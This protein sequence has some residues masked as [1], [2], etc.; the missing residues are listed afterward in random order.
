MKLA[1]C[2][3]SPRGYPHSEAFREVAQALHAAAVALGHDAVLTDRADLPGRQTIVFGPNLLARFPQPLSP[4]AI[5]YNLEQ[6]GDGPWFEPA[7]LELFRKSP[8]WDYSER[9]AANLAAMGVPRPRV[10]PV[11]WDPVLERI[12]PSAEDIDVLFYGSTNPRRLRVLEALQQAGARVEIAWNV[13]GS[14]RDE[15][16][17]RSRVVLNL[18]YF[19]AKVFEIV[20][21]SYLLANG[22]AVVSERGAAPE[23]EAPFEEAVRFADYDGLVP[24]CLDLLSNERERARLG[25]A[26][27]RIMRARPETGILK[28][29]LWASALA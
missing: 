1:V 10:V 9:N 21:V 12:A 3:V 23:E 2:I 13:Y 27:R 6:A 22:R 24:A 7:V 4:G 17:A 26:G 16:I 29:A 11:G 8:V 15:L 28:E 14:R 5:L 18:H 19:E 25:E 20:R